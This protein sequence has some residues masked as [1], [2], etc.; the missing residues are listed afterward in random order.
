MVKLLAEDACAK[1][2]LFLHVTGRRADGYHQLDSI[3]VP[4]SISDRITIEIRPASAAKV[5]LRCDLPSLG[6]PESNLAMRAARAYLR[7]FGISA[8]VTI[9][10]RKVIPVGAGLGGGSSDAGS[11]LRIMMA[12][13]KPHPAN[14]VSTR[15]QKLAVGLGADVPFFLDPRP[16]RVTGIGEVIAP[17]N[18]F[19]TLH[20][21]IAVPEVEVPTASVFKALQR[22]HWSGAA[23]DID[24]DAILRGDIHDEH[25]VNDLEAPAM[26][27]YPQI[28]NLK[29][30]L[31]ECGATASSMSGSGGAV[32]GIFPDA[33]AAARAAER[34]HIKAPEA[35]VL[36][37]KSLPN[38]PPTAD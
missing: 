24:I 35:R 4:I 25:L 19:P 15:L 3:F 8:Q 7:E 29:K 17:L 37:A 21:V 9:D 12:M 13:L 14:D 23:S 16:A 33:N 36:A 6:D 38:R 27:L 31:Q 20:L 1:I 26:A 28:A 22:D 2:N 30:M 5:S 34:L 10:L 32:F 18:R 11:V